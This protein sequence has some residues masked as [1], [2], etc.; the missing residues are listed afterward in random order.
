MKYNC[1]TL[2]TSMAL[3]REKWEKNLKISNLGY[4][5]SKA[6]KIMLVLYSP[7]GISAR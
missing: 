6:S 7:I 4:S 2:A 1:V 5:S 3:S